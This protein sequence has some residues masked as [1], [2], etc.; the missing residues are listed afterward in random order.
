MVRSVITHAGECH[1]YH[2]NARQVTNS[3]SGHGWRLGF[4]AGIPNAAGTE[5][6]GMV[7]PATTQVALHTHGS[8]VY[9]IHICIGILDNTM[10]GE[11]RRKNTPRRRKVVACG[12]GRLSLVC[13]GAGTCMRRHTH[14]TY[15]HSTAHTAMWE[16]CGGIYAC[17]RGRHT[18]MH[19]VQRPGEG[20]RHTHTECHNGVVGVVVGKG[21]NEMGKGVGWG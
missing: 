4:R 9:N 20:K 8:N 6:T 2:A 18:H 13:M 16:C 12:G 3:W 10:S 5:L 17:G 14:H 21:N 7:Q 19:K 1:R 15:T 11:G